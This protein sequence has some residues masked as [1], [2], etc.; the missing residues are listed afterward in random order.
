MSKTAL[1]VI[2]F[3]NDLVQ[4]D[5]K[6]ATA[7]QFIQNHHV[8][9]KA[10]EAIKFARNNNYL[11]IFI[12]VGFSKS[13]IECPDQS[14]LFGKIKI[15]GGLQLNTHGAEFHPQLDIQ[16]YDPIIIK[17]RIS[18]FYAS[19]LEA[20][21]RAQDIDT[22]IISGIS[23]NFAVYSAALESHDRNYKV[24]ILQD[25]CAA[26]NETMHNNALESL[27]RIAQIINVDE[28]KN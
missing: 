7:A 17:H 14:P 18:V 3:I 20:V 24:I 8:I 6:L 19:E 11:V 16:P 13:Y 12:K 5:S 4:P 15:I 1:L 2:D 25:A 27:S 21:L 26:A 10:N 22:I 9:E 28:L 23:T